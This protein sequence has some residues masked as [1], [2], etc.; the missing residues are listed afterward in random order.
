MKVQTR[1]S[2]FSSIAFGVV[3]AAISLLVYAL[4]SR[5]AEDGVYKDLKNSAHVV[6]LFHF[7]E[8][9][10]NSKDFSKVEKQFNE[11]MHGITYQVYDS[12]NKLILGEK[13]KTE[14]VATL[15]KIRESRN[16]NFIA[17]EEYCHGLY[18]ED[19]QGDFVIVTKESR[20]I[21]NEQL[22]TLLTILISALV[23]GLIA[24]I[25]LS[26]WLA[27]IAY[28]PV[29]RVINQVETLSL[30]NAEAQIDSPNTKDELQE[31]TE[32]FN[33]LLAHISETFLIQKNFVNY[34]SHEFRT[35][36]AS[37]MGNLEVFSLKDRTPAEYERLAV[38]LISEIMRLK[39]ILNT[40][41]VISDL[42]KNSD[43]LNR[44][45]MDEL[46]WEIIENVSNLYK[47]SNIHP[48]VEILPEDESLLTVNLNRTQLY[49]AL[50]NIIEN[51]VKYS[52]PKSV[53][54]T[55]YKQNHQ[56][57]VSV[58]DNGIGIPPEELKNISKPFFRANNT[59]KIQGS[60]I[61]LSIALRILEKIGIKYDIISEQGNGTLVTLSF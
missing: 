33:E 30:D 50:F 51:A 53:Q 47:N 17:E 61:G 49:M 2:L 31:L 15:G 43:V 20:A 25:L 56:L 29:S 11:I 19:N 59:N 18:Y 8:D 52:A 39:E 13:Q 37:M 5:K 60:G 9:E 12:S 14:N 6:G 4:Y 21:L 38:E 26:R 3:F 32:T 48:S 42:R 57:Q 54:I 22:I 23:I 28:R 44:I 55:I 27:R 34:V 58:K 46:V 45:R 10:L 35:P 41:L 40:L 36:L 24:V 1:L 16:L 7:E